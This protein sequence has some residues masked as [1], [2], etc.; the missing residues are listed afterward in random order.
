M[1]GRWD[2]GGGWS[3]QVAVALG[4]SGHGLGWRY[5]SGTLDVGFGDAGH[6]LTGYWVR[7]RVRGLGLALSVWLGSVRSRSGGRVPGGGL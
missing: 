4:R 5:G 6:G 3:G 7:F 2:G 1:L